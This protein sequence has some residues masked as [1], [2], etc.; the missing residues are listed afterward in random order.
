MKNRRIIYKILGVLVLLFGLS[1]RLNSTGCPFV[2]LL[3]KVN[4]A[5]VDISSYALGYGDYYDNYDNLTISGTLTNNGGTLINYSGASLTIQNGASLENHSYSLLTNTGT[6]TNSGSLNNYNGASLDNT[7]TLTNTGDLINSGPLGTLTNTGTLNNSGYLNNSGGA[8]LDN[9]GTLTNTGTLYNTS[10]TLNNYGT[11]TNS[12]AITNLG[13]LTNAGTLNNNYLLTNYLFLTNNDT[14]TNT[15]ILINLGILNNNGILNNS[16]TLRNYGNLTNT[17]P[18]TNTDTLIN[19]SG[20]TLTNS[21][22]LTNQIGATLTNSGTLNNYSGASLTNNGTLTNSGGATLTNN[23]TLTNSIVA[24]LTNN[25]TLTNSSGASLNNAGTLNNS[26]SLVNNGVL[27]VST[28]GTLNVTDGT[29]SGNV[30]TL[31][32]TMNVTG[33]TVSSGTAIESGATM[34]V[35]GGTISGAIVNNGTLAVSGGNFLLAGGNTTGR[36]LTISQLTGN[37]HFVI[38][39]DVAHNLADTITINDST[40]H[41]TNT[42]KVN[43]DPSF[44]T[45]QAVTGTATFATTA[46][47]NVTF[48]ATA[49][50]YGAYQFT[51]ILAVNGTTWSITGFTSNA[52]PSQTVHSG[53][54]TATGNLA[55]WRVENNNLTR[56]LGE[57][58]SSQGQAGEWFRVYRGKQET[59][60]S[61]LS[62]QYMAIQGGYDTKHEKKGGAWF[63]GYT[64]GYLHGDNTLERGSGTGSSVTLGA[65]ASW[66]GESGDYLDLIA[67][68]GRLRNSF[69]SYLNNASATKVSG[70]YA[71]W[72]TSLSAEYGHRQKLQNAWYLEPQAEINLARITSASYITSDGT[73]AYAAG[74]NSVIGRAGIAIGRDEKKY[75][76]YIKTS[77]A[78]ELKANPKITMESGGFPGITLGQSLKDTW[79][80][81]DL[82]WTAAYNKNVNSYVEISRTTG[83]LLNTPWQFNVGIRKS[84]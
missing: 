69:D 71:N 44:L 75:S 64:V 72:G 42:V 36:S 26:G 77:L 25:G 50:D 43:Y 49:T 62:Q 32:G 78:R 24:T 45:G 39:T 52:G 41:G 8:S 58:R 57:L 13:T 11:L 68:Q 27:T 7:G 35:S 46:S 37:A 5:N 79:L 59:S 18:L 81:Y 56:R 34:S 40:S 55:Q 20:A 12:G 83:G 30:I 3:P 48:Q 53:L 14:L 1:F 38:N 22:T 10:G 6:L 60:D 47:G 16:G 17:G 19:Y 2:T 51:P 67:K 33:G 28:T 84:F 61:Q 21:G 74:V 31:Y 9:S 76:F 66:L 80:E 63:T 65:Y 15:D 29:V 82:G 54:H 73:S 70:S 23:G 4:A